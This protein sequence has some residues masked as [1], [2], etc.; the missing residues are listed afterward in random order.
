MRRRLLIGFE[1]AIVVGIVVAG[2][3]TWR[4]EHNDGRDDEA[5]PVPPGSVAT[6]VLYQAPDP[7]ATAMMVDVM[8]ACLAVAGSAV[9]VN[10]TFVTIFDATDR[11][12]VDDC[13]R[14]ILVP[15]VPTASP[16]EASINACLLQHGASATI[17]LSGTL[18]I[19]LDRQILGMCLGELVGAPR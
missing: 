10:P 6:A 8:N 17:K 2:I 12:A 9:R 14:S 7:A 16:I 13:A 19:G 1:V 3:V 4:A 5:L 18:P 15:Q 11:P